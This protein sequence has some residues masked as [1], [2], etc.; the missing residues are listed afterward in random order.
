MSLFCGGAFCFGTQRT[1]G[2]CTA[3][4]AVGPAWHW[5]WAGRYQRGAPGK[6]WRLAAAELDGVSTLMLHGCR[7]GL[8]LVYTSNSKPHAALVA[9]ATSHFS[10]PPV[11][12]SATPTPTLRLYAHPTPITRRRLAAG[13]R[14]SAAEPSSRPYCELV[15]TRHR[16]DL[17]RWRQATTDAGFCTGSVDS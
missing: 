3:K 15:E 17:L 12:G 2:R 16:T 4:G 11:G 6:R 13:A 14:D 8:G 1:N 5:R 10:N 7:R 9:A